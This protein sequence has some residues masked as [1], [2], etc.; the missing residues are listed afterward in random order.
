MSGSF[1]LL[2]VGLGFI[3]ETANNK[4]QSLQHHDKR[5]YKEPKL[6]LLLRKYE[7]THTVSFMITQAQTR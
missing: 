1:V 4:F 6:M 5:H 2:G 3:T 7:V